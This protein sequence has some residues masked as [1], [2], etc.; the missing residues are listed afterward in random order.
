MLFQKLVEQHRVHRLVT[1]GVGLPFRRVRPDRD[2]PF[3]LPRPRGRTAGCHPG[4]A[5]LVTEGDRLEGEDRFARLVH[6]LD[7]FLVARGGS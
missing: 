5:L 4:Q 1:H 6:R 2:S 7:L 3:P